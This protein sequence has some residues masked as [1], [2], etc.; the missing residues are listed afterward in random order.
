M[1]WLFISAALANPFTP[2]GIAWKFS[3]ERVDASQIPVELA[4]MRRL[5]AESPNWPFAYTDALT[6]RVSMR[7]AVLRETNPNLTGLLG[8][9]E[10][11]SLALAPRQSGWWGPF[12]VVHDDETSYFRTQTGMVRHHQETAIEAISVERRRFSTEKNAMYSS[13]DYDESLSVENIVILYHQGRAVAFYEYES[14][15]TYYPKYTAQQWTGR[16]LTPPDW[17]KVIT[18]S[19]HE[20]HETIQLFSY[21]EDGS[22]AQIDVYDISHTHI[23]H[24]TYTPQP[25]NP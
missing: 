8:L 5:K 20:T 6:S 10:R 11:G 13:E 23:N 7:G 9:F 24:E 19:S 15:L 14:T 16:E 12:T 3:Y 25:L 18:D 21:N 22:L 2:P 17:L 4:L 1:V